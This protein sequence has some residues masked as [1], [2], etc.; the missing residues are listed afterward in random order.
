[1]KKKI[2]VVDDDEKNRKL[3][4]DVLNYKG[5]EVYLCENGRTALSK[6]HAGFAL[7]LVMTDF[8]MPGMNGLELTRKIKAF[9]PGLP[10]I[11]MTSTS[12]LITGENPADAVINKP[13][14]PKKLI[15]TIKELIN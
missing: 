7:D 2:L 11:I 4:K 15:K 13:L 10:V 9:M 6:I 8:M 3:L 5:Y 14:S 12:D 1:M